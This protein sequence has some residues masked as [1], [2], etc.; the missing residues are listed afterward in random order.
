MVAIVD[1]GGGLP[2][3]FGAVIVASPIG[4]AIAP[5]F[6]TIIRFFPP[7][8]TGVVITTIG[9]T[10]LPVAVM[11]AMGSNPSAE[12]FGSAQNVGLAALTFVIVL[13]LSKL[14]S[15]TISRLAILLAIV[16]GTVVAALTRGNSSRASVL[17]ASPARMVRADELAA[18]VEGDSFVGGRLIDKDGH[19][20]PVTGRQGD[21]AQ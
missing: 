5:L 17:A 6:A 15:A 4:L 9:L 1:G 20:V 11:W 8:V 12:T 16:A 2:A 10:L 3:V 18:L 19:E 13:A 7:V 14:G 21:S